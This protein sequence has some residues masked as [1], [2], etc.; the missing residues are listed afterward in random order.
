MSRKILFAVCLIGPPSS[1]KGTLARKMSS[2]WGVPVVTPG[3]IYKDLRERDT[4]MGRI[5]RESLAG[6]GLCPDSLTNRI[7]LEESDR[8][9]AEGRDCVILDGYPRTLEQY[10]FLIKNFFV[11]S[12]VHLESPY[13]VLESM[14]LNRVQCPDC[15]LVGSLLRPEALCACQ[16]KTGWKR[17]FDD[18]AE[19]FPSRIATY[20]EL[21]QPII[22]A[23]SDDYRYL[24]F[25]SLAEPDEEPQALRVLDSLVALA[26][27]ISDIG[28]AMV[29]AGG[30]SA[31]ERV[32]K[33]QEFEA[34]GIKGFGLS[35][36]PYNFPRSARPC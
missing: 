21:T 26:R 11:A 14:A 3:D 32:A 22:D 31:E 8:L 12:F 29:E 19:M 7:M 5:V 4:E 9:A 24:K 17:R 6:G 28:D 30:W 10:R 35:G 25:D 27:A 15:G 36:Q 2:R 1:G 34:S 18:T 20:G 33:R 16:P 13:G 23:V